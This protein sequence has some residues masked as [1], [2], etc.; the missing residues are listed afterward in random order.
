MSGWEK[1][2]IP[3]QLYP[4]HGLLQ[5]AML[6]DLLKIPLLHLKKA[7][8]YSDGLYLPQYLMKLWDKW[9]WFILVKSSASVIITFRQ[10]I[11]NGK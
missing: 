5:G 8:L 3:A 10:G 11:R 2:Q 6:G 4:G 7:I 9:H 1:Q